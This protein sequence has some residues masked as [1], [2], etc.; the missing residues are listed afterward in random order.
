MTA[1]YRD[2]LKSDPQVTRIFVQVGA[3]VVS[4]SRNQIHQ[5]TCEP[6][7][8]AQYIDFD[9]P[10]TPRQKV[11]ANCMSHKLSSSGERELPCC[12]DLTSPLEQY[13]RL[14]TG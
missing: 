10:S 2:G 12:T 1:S 3:E 9:T 6:F 11:T 5:T 13:G 8:G 14:A 7:A 4:N